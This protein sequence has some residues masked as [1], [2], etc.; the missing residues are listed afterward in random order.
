MSKLAFLTSQSSVYQLDRYV[1]ENPSNSTTETDH[2]LSIHFGKPWGVSWAMAVSALQQLTFKARQQNMVVDLV[3]LQP[4]DKQDGQDFFWSPLMSPSI[5]DRVVIAELKRLFTEA[6]S[7][8]PLCT[9]WTL[10]LNLIPI[11]VVSRGFEEGEY[12][13]DLTDPLNLALQ[14]EIDHINEKSDN[15]KVTR[16]VAMPDFDPFRLA[17]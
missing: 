4:F 15:I 1:N 16:V 17:S 7:D 6:L 13:E 3:A 10:T 2:E 14:H 9:E 5:Q 8:K 12:H 11:D